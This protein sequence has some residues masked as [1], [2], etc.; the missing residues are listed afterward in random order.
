VKSNLI[1]LAVPFFFLAIFIEA[2]ISRRKKL[3]VYRLHDSLSNLSGGIGHEVLGGFTTALGLYV[4]DLLQTRYGLLKISTSSVAAWL[5]LLVAYDFCYYLYHWASHRVNFLWATHAVHH[6]S[7]EY[8]LSVALRQSWFTRVTSWVFYV[9]LALLGFPLVMYLTIGAINL[10]YQFWIHTRPVGRLGFLELFL[11]TPSHHR[12]HHGIDP[13]YI[14][15]N[16]GGMFIVFDRLFGTFI[17]EHGEP[18]YGTVKPLSTYD[19]IRANLVE[20]VRLW[21]MSRRTRRLADKIKIWFM[22]PEWQPADLGGE[23]EI[24][25][26]SRATQRKYDVR[27]APAITAY[28]TFSFTLVLLASVYFLWIQH[29]L[30]LGLRI[31]YAGEAVLGMYTVAALIEGRPHVRWLEVLRLLSVAALA[32]LVPMPLRAV[33]L[34]AVASSLGA[35]LYLQLRVHEAPQIETA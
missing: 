21:D 10:L 24:P 19:P 5:V 8:N 28:A 18:V 20:W 26:V 7:E 31:V 27:C 22:P 23:V 14:D 33:L 11:N 17:E 12:V 13:R 29:E 15:K 32:V 25:E 9:P 6:Q 3:G 16:H 30:D 2:M 35:M 34:G 4:Y 1:A